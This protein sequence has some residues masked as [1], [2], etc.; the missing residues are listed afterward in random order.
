M[1][2]IPSTVSGFRTLFIF[3][4]LLLLALSIFSIVKV[5]D[6]IHAADMV[7]H[8][9]LVNLTLQDISATITEA[10][11]NQRGFLLTGDSVLLSEMEENL[12]VLNARIDKLDSLIQDNPTQIANVQALRKVVSEKVAMMRK[13]LESHVSLAITSGFNENIHEGISRMNRVK[14]RINTMLEIEGNL[15]NARLGNYDRQTFITP[16]LTII[17][18]IGGLAFLLVSYRRIVKELRYSGE[19]RSRLQEQRLF[20]ESLITHGPYIIAAY[21][22]EL[23]AIMW[24]QKS[25]EYTGLK[26]HEA[27]GKNYFTLF[28][29]NNNPEW[30]T[31]LNE[32]LAGKSK[33]FA[34]FKLHNKDAWGD[35][36]LAPLVNTQNET[37]GVLT[38]ILDIT[39]QLSAVSGLKASEDRYHLM[40]GEVEDYAI[41]S[42]NEHGIIENWNKGAE[43]IKGYKAEEIVGKSFSVFYPAEDQKNRLPQTLLATAAREGKAIHEGWRVRKDGTK[44]WGSVVISA[45]YDES[46]KVIGFSKVT[47]DLTERK[48]ADDYRKQYTEELQQKNT[49]L[50]KMN[51]ELESFAYVSSHDLQEP[52]RKITTFANRIMEKEYSAL[53][54]T[55]KDYLNRM[56]EA[57]KR[58]KRL[59]QD[60]LEYSRT[61]TMERTFV[62]TDIKDLV[63]G[64]KKEFS[65]VLQEKSG[66]INIGPLCKLDVV[67]FQFRQLMENLIGNSLKFSVPGNPPQINVD[68][69]VKTGSELNVDGLLPKQS[70]CHLWVTDNGI[71]FDPQYKD[72]IFEVFQ[73][74][75]AREEFEGTG[76]GLAICKKIVENHNGVITADSTEGKGA[77]FD[78][79]IPRPAEEATRPSPGTVVVN[80]NTH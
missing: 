21:D 33:R 9:N 60:L 53:S 79:Y 32:V 2:V 1:R 44:F 10:Q 64:V 36:L 28:P 59:I 7:R 46:H 72:R 19:L 63:E 13:V 50:E 66:A 34:K 61:N 5:R 78:I 22:K 75:N 47:R 42:L 67:P 8:T 51:K 48:L 71:G 73:R 54:E 4:L 56:Q 25:A 20:A 57:A 65:E 35:V 76:I 18:M 45:L 12:V 6:L 80:S 17:L 58:M 39:E 55:G 41:L 31:A 49:I 27:I 70:Y 77:R 23:K 62:R 24:N 40:V 29:E 14:N 43:K 37:I 69:E 52:L 74:L 15:I 38:M 68:S 26:S 16:V 3:S 11:T 30:K